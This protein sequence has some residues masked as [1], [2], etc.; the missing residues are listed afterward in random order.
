MDGGT[1]PAIGRPRAQQRRRSVSDLPPMT[2]AGGVASM[3]TSLSTAGLGEGERGVGERSKRRSLTDVAGSGGGSKGD[4][5]R[6]VAGQVVQEHVRTDKGSFRDA[7]YTAMRLKS[8]AQ[9]LVGAMEKVID[10]YDPVTSFPPPPDATYIV[11][12]DATVRRDW[13]RRFAEHS[14]G[15]VLEAVRSRNV[16]EEL[17]RTDGHVVALTKHAAEHLVVAGRACLFVSADDFLRVVADASIAKRARRPSYADVDK[18]PAEPNAKEKL[19]K[20]KDLDDDRNRAAR[21]SGDRIDGRPKSAA[22]RKSVG[23]VVVETSRAADRDDPQLDVM[24][25]IAGQAIALQAAVNE[26]GCVCVPIVDQHYGH[27]AL[28]FQR[29]GKPMDLT[30]VTCMGRIMGVID[31]IRMASACCGAWEAGSTSNAHE[32]PRVVYEPPRGRRAASEPPAPDAPPRKQDPLQAA[33][34]ARSVARATP[35]TPGRAT[36]RTPGRSARGASPD[37]ADRA[38]TDEGAT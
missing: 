24:R 13:F 27:G 30:N 15:L 22:R 38:M 16:T 10:A 20:S 34:R 19:R 7:V 1:L 23:T 29:A 31:S 18:L 9:N 35:R 12:A 37:K 5:F 21:K 36:P 32:A 11:H 2:Q 17:L 3:L 33:A 6:R 8:R 25:R 26:D 14:K 4:L 28:C